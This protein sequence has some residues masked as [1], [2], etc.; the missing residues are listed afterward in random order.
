MNILNKAFYYTWNIGF[1]ERNVEDIIVSDDTMVDVHWVKH[2]YKDRFFA[3]PFILSVN[4][5]VIKVLVEDFP[6]YDKYGMI[7]LLML[8]TTLKLTLC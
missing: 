7:S 1:V 6:Y 8:L 5:K 3:D 2:N 4:D